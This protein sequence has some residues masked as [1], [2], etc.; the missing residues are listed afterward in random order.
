MTRSVLTHFPD[1]LAPERLE[2][3]PSGA[4]VVLP[5]IVE[6]KEG[7]SS[8]R[9]TATGLHYYKLLTGSM[10]GR[11]YSKKVQV[12]TLGP[13]EPRLDLLLEH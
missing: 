7:I 11:T 13:T 3:L 8:A 4:K 2:L 12:P 5:W 1:L 9:H 6:S 10:D